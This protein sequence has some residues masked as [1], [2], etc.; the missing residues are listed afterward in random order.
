M[1]A[2]CFLFVELEIKHCELSTNL[3][4]VI[5]LKNVKYEIK[6]SLSTNIKHRKLRKHRFCDI[7]VNFKH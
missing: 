6:I 7:F 3:K 2:S 1:D 5:T 4:I